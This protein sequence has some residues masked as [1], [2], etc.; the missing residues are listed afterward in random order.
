MSADIAPTPIPKFSRYRSVRQGAVAASKTTVPPPPPPPPPEQ[1]EKDELVTRSMSMSRYRPRT[2]SKPGQVANAP[3]PPTPK[4]P[5]SYDQSMTSS[6][7]PKGVGA[8]KQS[9]TGRAA[10]ALNQRKSRLPQNE[11]SPAVQEQLRESESE[12]KRGQ[13]KEALARE[14]QAYRRRK[15]REEQERIAQIEKAAQEAEQARLA[16]EET[17]RL[18]AEQKRKDLERLQAELDAAVPDSS[19]VTSPKEKF[20]LF[21]KRAGTKTSQPASS[22]T[23]SR[24]SSISRAKSDETSQGIEQGG[25]GIVPNVDAPISAVNAGERVSP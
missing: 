20:G 21:R 12:R 23:A 15:E 24:L 9:E 17:A 11:R 19:Q 13:A 7:R 22:G 6:E 25:G 5:Q 18:L 1:K 16:D 2:V 4:I 10:Q 8:D 3:I 14:E